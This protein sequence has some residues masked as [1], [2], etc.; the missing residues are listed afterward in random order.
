MPGVARRRLFGG[1]VSLG[2]LV[3][4]A[5]G[6]IPAAGPTAPQEPG[7]SGPGAGGGGPLQFWG[8][9]TTPGSPALEAWTK[10][11]ALFREA[12]PNVAYTRE[13]PAVAEGETFFQKVLAAA[14]AGTVPDVYMQDVTK[15][16]LG[17]SVPLGINRAV[18]D[19]LRQKPNLSK[20]FPWARQ[21]GQL[22]GKIWG[23]P[24]EVEF[25]SAFYSK[26]VFA[27]ASVKPGPQTWGELLQLGSTLKAGGVL[28]LQS[29]SGGDSPTRYNHVHGYL[30]ALIAGQPGMAEWLQDRGRW[31]ED[32]PFV[33][34]LDAM[35]SLSAAG[36][37]PQDPFDPKWSMPADWYNG[38]VAM[39]FNG[40]WGLAAYNKQKSDSP[41][42][43]FGQFPVPAPKGA[44]KPSL[45]GGIGN[46]YNIS[47]RARSPEAAAT[48]VDFLYSPPV[49][50]IFIELLFQPQPV[51]FKAA[52]YDVT[53][54]NREALTL[55]EQSVSQMPVAW[56]HVMTPDQ[57][58]EQG[59]LIT[60]VL[61]KE[62]PP[63][64]AGTRMQ[65]LWEQKA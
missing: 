9:G 6:S 46:G 45:M 28:P 11:D 52:D 32:S 34:A 23:F 65:Q 49:N 62:I 63:R 48:F 57:R 37:L 13:R 17:E 42:F 16:E 27:K 40:T 36:V 33:V 51:P 10:I 41:G 59:P 58:K 12:H 18:D 5:C 2:G 64:Q 55:M 20:I 56:W 8:G 15:S 14:V 4:A 53:A 24:S 1:A 31:D 50:K 26:P 7:R 29:A 43:D 19:L 39:T 30:M 54:A 38:Q 44:G 35:L 61:K 47:A 3:A 60:S 25:V 22:Q 21:L